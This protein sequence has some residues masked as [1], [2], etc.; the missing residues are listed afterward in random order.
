M[1]DW[2]LLQDAPLR[3]DATGGWWHGDEPLT[4]KVAALF[5]RNVALDALGNYTVRLGRNLAPLQVDVTPFV[6]RSAQVQWDA[7]VCVGVTLHVSDGAVEPLEAATLTQSDGHV[8]YCSIERAGHRVPCRFLPGP[9][10]A[11]ALHVMPDAKQVDAYVLRL[12]ER[13]HRIAQGT[14]RARRLAAR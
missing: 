2:F 9:Y 1:A 7:G 3:V 10:H 13:A 11:L 12:G 5:A 6:V 8:L 14:P 4:G